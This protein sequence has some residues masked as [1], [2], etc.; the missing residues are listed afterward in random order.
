MSR[1]APNDS[2][3]PRG[4][5]AYDLLRF[6]HENPGKRPKDIKKALAHHRIGG[7]WMRHLKDHEY[8]VN[9]HILPWQALFE[10][11]ASGHPQ[12]EFSSENMDEWLAWRRSWPEQLKAYERPAYVLTN[13]GRMRLK[14]LAEKFGEVAFG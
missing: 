7:H 2:S 10:A 12:P 11:W 13:K 6:I 1:G 8:A 9:I 14:K 3:L 5:V 4:R